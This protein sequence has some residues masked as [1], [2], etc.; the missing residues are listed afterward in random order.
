MG[1]DGIFEVM[2]STEIVGFVYEILEEKK[3]KITKEDIPNEI[4]EECRNRWTILNKYQDI[5]MIKAIKASGT[6][7]AINNYVIDYVN[8]ITEECISFGEQTAIPGSVNNKDDK[9]MTINN[10]TDFETILTGKHNIDD[11]SCVIYFLK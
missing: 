2:N 9:S 7:E 3:G 5:Q 11:L 1:S 4:V 6:G 10:D 8:Y